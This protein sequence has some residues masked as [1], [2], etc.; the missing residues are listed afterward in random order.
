MVLSGC[1]SSTG[2]D[3]AEV[4]FDPTKL[5]IRAVD[6]KT[7][8][9]KLNAVTPY[10]LELTAFP[11]YAPVRT[12]IISQHGEAWAITPETYIGNGQYKMTEYVSGSYIKMVKNEHYWAPVTGPDTLVF[13]LIS[14]DTA[15]YNAFQTGELAFV[16]TIPPA[17]I[18]SLLADPEFHVE[19]QLGTYYLSYNTQAE[20]F[21]DP[22]VRQ[23]FTL[24]ID[25][26]YI[27]NQIGDGLYIAAGA[28]V[29]P[30]LLDTDP[31]SQFRTNGGDYYDPSAAAYAAN[32]ATAQDLLVQAGYPGGQGLPTINY[33]YN[34]E[35]SMH[36]SVAE[37][38]QDMWGQLGATVNIEAQ[39][40]STFT[41]TRRNG[42]YQV[43]RNGWLTDYNDPISMLDLFTTDSGN[44]DSQW[45]NP[46]YDTLISQV[47]SSGERAQRMQLMHQA[48]DMIF[49]DWML[50]PIMYY[51]DVYMQKSDLDSSV[52]TSPLGYKYFME[53][54]NYPTLDVCIGPNPE[55][56]DPALNTTADGGTMIIH[57][58]EG[59]YRLGH[60][61][62]PE[63][64]M[65]ES[66]DV[67]ADGLTY[68]FHLRDG[69]K[70]SD[71][72][73]ITAQDFVDSWLRAIDPATGAYYGY[74]FESIAGYSEA[75]GGE[76]S[77]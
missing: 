56:M 54:Q 55:S 46:A 4:F 6:D 44:N 63:P 59:L 67:S 62:L 47:K 17:E 70:W 7:L 31:G 25:R 9:V 37:A 76:G 53:A 39:E 20:P 74:M 38:L 42:D 24:A 36:E 30:G 40:W 16:D 5:A 32:L 14:D 21:D 22:L 43:A 69:I 23:A 50:C 19:S 58:F 48:E 10:F 29:P 49:D 77:V 45:S 73:A 52:W 28:F 51:A 34:K 71:G 75:L 66:V 41:A 8:E 60:D 18:P 35:D 13:H 3:T 64:A 26:D 65:A 61:G 12:D 1:G 57:A 72:N 2:T 33:L 27:A 15:Q 68:T 11:T